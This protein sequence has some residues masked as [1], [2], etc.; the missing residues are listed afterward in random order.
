VAQKALL[1]QKGDTVA[2]RAYAKRYAQA[3]FQIA[4]E[5]GELDNWQADLN[6][7]AEVGQ[8]AGVVAFLDSPRLPFS[9]RVKLLSDRLTDISPLALN[10]INL[11]VAR[12]NMSI[13]SEIAGE[14][15]RLLD[16]YHGV[17]EARVVTAVPLDDE[18]RQRLEERLGAVV[19]KKVVI[20]SEVDASLVGGIVTRI[21]GKLMD[22]STRSQLAALKKEI[23]GARG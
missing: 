20:E 2:R 9:D 14:Y 22:G 1:T 5:K 8:D 15:R 12:G 17:E 21:G 11:L 18:S 7:I 19:D 23:S 13:A 3:V 6:K 16:S 4:V 10:L